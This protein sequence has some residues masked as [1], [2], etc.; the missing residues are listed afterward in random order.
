[1]LTINECAAKFSF[2]LPFLLVPFKG[3]FPKLWEELKRASTTM[4]VERITHQK[5]EL[6]T[7]NN[8]KN[9]LLHNYYYSLNNS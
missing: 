7:I 9:N 1:M 6:I 2:I 5:M 8:G 3:S 4:I